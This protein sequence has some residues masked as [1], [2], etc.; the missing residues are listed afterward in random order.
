MLIPTD[1]A[2]GGGLR[3][4]QTLSRRG[5][6]YKG[7]RLVSLSIPY[8]TAVRLTGV[9]LIRLGSAVHQPN[10]LIFQGATG[11]EAVSYTFACHVD[12]SVLGQDAN[13][14]YDFS[15]S[16]EDPVVCDSTYMTDLTIEMEFWQTDVSPP[17]RTELPLVAAHNL[18]V[19]LE[20]L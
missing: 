10:T 3:Y 1:A 9:C 8:T 16:V 13:F 20:I 5:H 12:F 18:T 11:P 15:R 4:T 19:L 17:V 7:F 14:V 2:Q 6:T